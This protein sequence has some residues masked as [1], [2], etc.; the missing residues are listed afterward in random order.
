MMPRALAATSTSVTFLLTGVERIEILKGSQGTLYGSDAIAGVIN[1]ITRKAGAK[2]LSVY[3][4]ASA[5]SFSTIRA[6]AG[7]AGKTKAVDYNIGYSLFDTKGFS[8]AQKS[9]TS[10]DDFEA[11]EYSQNSV[12]ASIGIQATT[13]LRLQPYVRYTKNNGDL[14]QQGYVDENDYTYNS[15]NLQTGVRNEINIGKSK[16]NILYQYNK[17]NRSYLDDSTGSRNGFYTYN[18]SAYKASEHF[19]EAYVVVP[20]SGVTLTA[21]A[22]LRASNTDQESF[23][24]YGAGKTFSGDSL[25]QAQVAFYSALNY[26]GANGLGIE[27]GGRFNNHSEYGSNFAFNVN[28]Y[29]LLSKQWKVFANVSSG[30]KTPS[31]YQLFS[32]YGNKDLNPETSVNLEGGVQYFTKDEKASIRAIYFQRRVR[33]A[34]AF[35]FN[36][37]TFASQYINQDRQKDNGFELDARFNVNDKVHV[38]AFYSYADGEVTTKKGGKDTTFFNLYRRPLSTL[39]LQLGSQVTKALFVSANLQ[40]VSNTTDVTFEP[41]TYAQREIKLKNYVLINLYGEYAIVQ[42]RFKI[43]A[44]LRNVS[45]ENYATI[46][47]YSSARFNAYG[48]FR[49]SF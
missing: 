17:T 2:P 48:G 12:H 43:F 49:F 32:Q 7:V 35:F 10:V 8:E 41:P 6:S 46:Y 31:L 4:T 15:E 19:A 40:A 34:I 29:Y 33:D 11:D 39:T 47:G 38:K 14:D 20:F 42:N 13:K 5:G 3:G 18:S 27:A 37:A 24:N 23:T 36:P 25:K 26:S 28:P 22:D 16:F 45:N 1:I 21:G 44:D 30:Y 9:R